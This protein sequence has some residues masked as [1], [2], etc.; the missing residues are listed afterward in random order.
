LEKC[1]LRSKHVINLGFHPSELASNPRQCEGGMKVVETVQFLQITYSEFCNHFGISHPIIKERTF[2]RKETIPPEAVAAFQT[3][4]SML[5]S[6]P[7]IDYPN[8]IVLMC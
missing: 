5:V 4:Q 3:L 1:V 6:E 2:W 7:V 8:G